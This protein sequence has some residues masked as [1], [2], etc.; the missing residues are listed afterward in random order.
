MAEQAQASEW[1]CRRA[2]G[3]STFRTDLQLD[4][5]L[6]RNGRPR[7]TFRPP[8]RCSNSAISCSDRSKSPVKKAH[9]AAPRAHRLNVKLY[10][11]DPIPVPPTEP[12]PAARYGT[13]P[14][15]GP[16]DAL[17][18]RPAR[19]LNRCHLRAFSSWPVSRRSAPDSADSRPS[20]E[21]A[22]VKLVPP[23]CVERSARP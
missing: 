1:R 6:G 18:R 10:S 12:W 17:A 2:C 8:A 7:S 3:F 16:P 19:R 5:Q 21:I 14:T 15:H 13:P 22:S 9:A 20:K 23:S 4:L 11:R